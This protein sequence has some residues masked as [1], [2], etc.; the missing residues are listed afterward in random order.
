MPL[1]KEAMISKLDAL[2]KVTDSIRKAQ[3]AAPIGGQIMANQGVIN[4]LATGFTQKFL[5]K[6]PM[7]VGDILQV[8]LDKSKSKGFD[9]AM[10]VLND[11]DFLAN[12]NAI[13][14]GQARKAEALEKKLMK[15][16]KMKDFINSLPTNEA[17][18]I[19]VLGFTSWL[20]R[21]EDQNTNE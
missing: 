20:S 11:P 1:I 14:K 10:E 7:L 15:K 5:T 8:G 18:A 16:K 4:K 13:A 17:K 2:G 6:L 9:K 3:D 19:S 21:Y 12:I